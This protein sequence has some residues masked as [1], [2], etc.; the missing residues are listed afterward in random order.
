MPEEYFQ[1]LAEKTKRLDNCSIIRH[2]FK[3][4]SPMWIRESETYV[5]W[6]WI[7]I[8]S[9]TASLAVSLAIWRGLFLAVGRLVK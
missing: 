5:H 6:N 4:P 7:A 1:T 2:N 9:Y 8:F 3:E